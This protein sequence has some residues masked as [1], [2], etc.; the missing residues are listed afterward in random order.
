MELKNIVEWF[1]KA[2]PAPTMKDLCVQVGCHLEE[3]AEMLNS[4]GYGSEEAHEASLKAESALEELANMFKNGGISSFTFDPVA[5]LDAT[6][7]QCVTGVGIDYMMGANS[8]LAQR[9]VN[10]SNNSKFENGQPVFHE[11]GKIAKGKNYTPPDLAPFTDGY[12]KGRPQD[13][14]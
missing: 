9:E 4:F 7:D 5:T 14:L 8:V 1:E 12:F 3:V 11:T 2:K 6:R 10:R 13:E